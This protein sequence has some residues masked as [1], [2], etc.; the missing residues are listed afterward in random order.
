MAEDGSPT[1]SLD[2]RHALEAADGA[3]P[4]TGS[5]LDIAP[6]GDGA[7]D[8]DA[9][10]PGDGDA[11]AEG[12]G[13]WL[14]GPG[15]LRGSLGDRR[16]AAVLAVALAV[17]ALFRT[18]P[19]YGAV[20]RPGA[21]LL[22]PNDPYLYQFWV[23]RLSAGGSL[24]TPP[25][26]VR[27]GEPLFV[28][29]LSVV[30]I[31]LGGPTAAP[32]VVAW[33]PV[34]AGVAGAL[35]VYLLCVRVTDDVRVGIAAVFLIAVAPLHA[36]RTALGF[37]DHHA[38]DL[39]WTTLTATAAVS[40]LA[41]TPEAALEGVLSR[42]LGVLGVA[43]GVAGSTLAWEAGPLLL[44]PLGPLG[45]VVAASALRA[46]R[47]PA[48]DLAPLLAG[49]AGGALV[50]LVMHLAL[51]WHQPAVALA[52][53]LLAAGLAGVVGL[54]AVIDRVDAGAREFLLGSAGAG[55]VAAGAVLAIPSVVA[56]LSQGLDLLFRSDAIAETS[57]AF[58]DP[59]TAVSNF[60][61]VLL[62]GV[63]VLLWVTYTVVTGD[64][65]AWTVPVVYAWFAIALTAI[66]AR[67]AALASV[68]LSVFAGVGLVR[69]AAWVDAARPVAMPG[70]GD[71]ADARA[72]RPRIVGANGTTT[73]DDGSATVRTVEWP[74]AATATLLVVF[75][76]IVSVFGV[77]AT[78]A[79][80][81]DTT[82]DDDR[83]QVASAAAEYADDRGLPATNEERYVLSLWDENR[84]YNAL[85]GARYN[86][87]NFAL[88]NYPDFARTTD[89][90]EWYERHRGRVGFVVVDRTVFDAS[91]SPLFEG[92][93]LSPEA[94]TLPST[95]H[96]RALAAREGGD[97]VLYR[98]VPGAI[99]TG[100][101]PTNAT[102]T[103]TTQVSLEDQ[104]Y[105]YSRRA[106]PG[107]D[108]RFSVRVAYP[109]SYTVRTDSGDERG[110]VTVTDAAVENG[111]RVSADGAG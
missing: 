7:V 36:F 44:L 57:S 90:E 27:A 22:Y 15:P 51:G 72:E 67:F 29:L 103:V 31:V 30:A 3:D 17:F 59:L 88:F 79:L 63:P 62:L 91:G 6:P 69:I 38:F 25:E 21:V 96:Y 105:T 73:A 9:S 104:T 84:M 32:G 37:G 101:A 46:G 102:V 92:L 40:V 49:V 45:V 78:P 10:P 86:S 82:F 52:P 94:S 80:I 110:T 2:G 14:V 48:A 55:V 33:Y 109:G 60:G 65:R 35:L 26:P 58:P 23:E 106:Q 28:V 98:L 100:P 81:A 54:A 87:Y 111:T 61:A 24:L 74:G 43:A 47:S 39:V 18:V 4:G 20:F 53:T 19:A 76:L 99:V 12:P 68:F 75:G 8:T 41:D 64:R 77:A 66:Q 11:T 83:Y 107:D 85:S 13:R 97:L 56:E 93:E 16:V 89:T 108:G 5:A 71:D 1:A 34:V 50:V 42:R 70:R 95:A